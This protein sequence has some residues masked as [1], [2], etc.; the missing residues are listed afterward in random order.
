[1]PEF[2]DVRGLPD[3]QVQFV[4][5]LIEFMRHKRQEAISTPEAETINFRAW[6]LGTKGT[7]S[8]EE[9]YDYLDEQ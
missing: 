9:L 6:S 1:M 7:L 4:Q 2:I 8:R 3:E 5:Q